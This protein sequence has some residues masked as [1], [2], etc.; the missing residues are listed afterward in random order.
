MEA[1]KFCARTTFQR[2][3]PVNALCL[4]LTGTE[5]ATTIV[6]FF[7]EMAAYSSSVVPIY[8]NYLFPQK[9]I[10][11][12]LYSLLRAH[13]TA[14]GFRMGVIAILSEPALSYVQDPRVFSVFQAE[15]VTFLRGDL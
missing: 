13:E 14:P 1:L 2:A 7:E 3:R 11:R 4:G 15:E 5:K 8:V 12:T 6:K 10:D 9:E